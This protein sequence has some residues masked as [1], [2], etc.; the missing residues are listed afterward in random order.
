MFLQFLS[1]SQADKSLENVYLL[2]VFLFFLQVEQFHKAVF[3]MHVD[4]LKH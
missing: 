2:W 1:G 4:F 3:L